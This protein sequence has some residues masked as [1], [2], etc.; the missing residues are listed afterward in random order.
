ME[1]RVFS[2]LC[3]P[4]FGVPVMAIENI[5]YNHHTLRSQL[6]E[7]IDRMGEASSKAQGLYNVIT[8]GR[9]L[10]LS[11]HHLYIM[12][13]ANGNG[14]KG[15]VVGILK[16]GPKKLFVYS[17]H[18]AVHEMEPMCVLDFYVH[19]SRQRMGCGRKLFDFMIQDIGVTPVHLAIDRP[20]FKFSQFLSKHYNLR[21]E[22]PQVNNFVVF[23]GFFSNR[24]ETG[25][26]KRPGQGRPPV[27]RR[28]DPWVH[29]NDLQENV[30]DDGYQRSNTYAAY[31]GRPPLPPTNQNTGQGSSHFVTN[32]SGGQGTTSHLNGHGS[33]PPSGSSVKT[34]SA[35]VLSTARR[36]VGEYSRNGQLKP[37]AIE[38]IDVRSD[39][40]NVTA[41]ELINKGH[42][43]YSRHRNTGDT[44]IGSIQGSRPSSGSVPINRDITLNGVPNR[45]NNSEYKESSLKRTA[46]ANDAY[47]LNLHQEY[48]GRR[49]HLRTRNVDEHIRNPFLAPGED[50]PKTVLPWKPSIYEDQKTWTVFD[51]EPS[52]LSIASRNYTHTRLW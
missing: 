18:G 41:Q 40:R 4:W 32:H 28:R 15:A 37:L 9:K 8:T 48:Q 11:E 21:A 13:D 38:D 7:V 52:Y 6:L 35:S 5:M 22:I 16:I 39:S 17:H 27:G 25:G 43:M 14:G 29:Y 3:H 47:N 33:R 42:Q 20:S 50:L 26:K 30:F 36:E 34:R 24:P 23:E 19:E 12:K 45:N 10:Q 2:F 44:P 31:N 49:G 46:S 51:K 1:I